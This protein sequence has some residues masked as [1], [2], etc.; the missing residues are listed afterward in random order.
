MRVDHILR[1][2]ALGSLGPHACVIGVAT[3]A[4]PVSRRL[5]LLVAVIEGEV[6]GI[7]ASLM[8]ASYHASLSRRLVG[9]RLILILLRALKIVMIVGRLIYDEFMMV[10]SDMVMMISDGALALV[11]HV[12][13]TLVEDGLIDLLDAVFQIDWVYLVEHICQSRDGLVIQVVILSPWL[14]SI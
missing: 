7:V 5:L 2:L 9:T 11:M 6:P 10:V 8:N 13:S 12:P 1:A 3:D 4:A 14:K